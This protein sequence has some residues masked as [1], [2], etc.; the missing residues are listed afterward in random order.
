MLRSNEDRRWA[1]FEAELRSQTPIS[2]RH[3]PRGGRR[4][5]HRRLWELADS[6]AL[7]VAVHAALVA[8]ALL[9]C[10]EHAGEPAWL[11]LARE[12]GELLFSAMWA[13]E[14]ALKTAAYGIRGLVS[15]GED[16]VAVGCALASVAASALSLARA[17]ASCR[18]A[19]NDASALR[20]LRALRLV[21]L[22][23]V[24]KRLPGL[25]L[26]S[27]A[28]EAVLPLIARITLLIGVLLLVV[29]RLGVALFHGVDFSFDG[30]NPSAG[31]QST[32]GG[33]QLLWLT[34]TGELWVDFMEA[35]ALDGGGRHAWVAML[36]F[37]SFLVVM[38]FI[39]LN[40]FTMT[41]TE[42]YEVLRDE[43]RAQVRGRP[44]T[45]RPTRSTRARP[46]LSRRGPSPGVWQ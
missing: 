8:S 35:A 14:F 24:L 38:Q 16:A 23:Y 46:H 10:T 25:G 27:V 6:R 3:R 44:N 37:P 18:D 30:H 31:F 15:D 29:A 11:A 39:F 32:F 36:F 45:T 5:L 22:L 7:D 4:A 40:L 34:A 42:T 12:R 2:L 20:L 21:R 17:R 9:L 26:F 43:S 13:A 28:A 19:A 1:E 33:V 41:V